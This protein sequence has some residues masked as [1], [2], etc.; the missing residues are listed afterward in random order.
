MR[1]KTY[2]LLAILL[3]ALSLFASGCFLG[4]KKSEE[5]QPHLISLEQAETEPVRP[6]DGAETETLPNTHTERAQMDDLL[7]ILYDPDGLGYRPD[8]TSARDGVKKVYEEAEKILDRYIRND[9]T[10]FERVHAIHDWL[11][12]TVAYDFE[13]AARGDAANANDD[14]F[15]LTGVFVNRKAVCDGFSKAMCLLCGIEGIPCLRVTGSYVGDDGEEVAHA[16]N[17]VKIDGVWYNVDATMDNWHAFVG[18]TRYDVFNHGYFL[19]SD[20]A[21]S[22]ELTGRHAQSDTDEENYECPQNYP[23]HAG[24]ELGFGEHRMQITSQEELNA[25]FSYVKKQ[26][27]KKGRLELQLAFPEYE[28]GNLS[29]RNAYA[30]QIAA[31]YKKVKDSDFVMNAAENIYPY[32]RYPNGVFVFLIYK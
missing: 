21:I 32:R 9:F 27:G 2:A 1:K 20:E 7:C 22:D 3:V 5:L 12:Y 6:I 10:P 16:W 8:L 19:L 26:K 17:K 23:Y 15:G 18:N 13:L 30:T 24:E 28:N 31:A 25:V 4:H 14:A 11:A 29:R